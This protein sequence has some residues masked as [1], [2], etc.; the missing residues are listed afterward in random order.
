VRKLKYL[1][2]VPEGEKVTEKHLY[3]VLISS[4]CCIVLC[5]VCLVSTTWAWYTT[6]IVSEGNVIEIGTFRVDVTVDPAVEASTNS[7]GYVLAPGAYKIT[8]QNT[9]DTDGY[10]IVQLGDE[11]Y[12]TDTIGKDTAVSFSVTVY[13]S[14][15]SVT[16]MVFPKWGSGG[17][18]TLQNENFFGETVVT[19]DPSEESVDN[20][21]STNE[22]TAPQPENNT[23]EPDASEPDASEPDTSESDA[24]V[25]TE[26]TAPSENP[27]VDGNG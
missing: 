24:T 14:L 1:F 21:S 5:M 23:Q 15:E 27:Q 26:P 8:I 3:R 6:T 9:G 19:P 25:E 2:T 11:R 7:D 17:D 13:N 12:E 20:N 4:I 10:C 22:S 16:V 18:A